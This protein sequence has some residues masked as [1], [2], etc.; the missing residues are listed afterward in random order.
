MN[1]ATIEAASSP[2]DIHG[3][4]LIASVW[5]CKRAEWSR[6]GRMLEALRIEHANDDRVGAGSKTGVESV[7]ITSRR[8]DSGDIH[9]A[10]VELTV[11]GD[12]PAL[13]G[14]DINSLLKRFGSV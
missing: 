13:R 8:V 5:P 9:P 7:A 2:S 3:K 10:V 6:A 1:R 11:T 4:R 14:P 12:V